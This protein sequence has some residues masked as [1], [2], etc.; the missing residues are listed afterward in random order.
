MR[1]LDV[2]VDRIK[3]ALGWG[4]EKLGRLKLNGRL[5]GYS[6]LSRLVEL[7]ALILG[8]RGK[9]AMWVALKELQPAAARTARVDLD[10]LSAR[11]EKQLL[12][13]EQQ[14]LRAVPEALS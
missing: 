2:D 9:L 1:A 12:G 7:E 5:F 8:A 4:A 10:R 11:A 6:P 14:R 13:L 3:V